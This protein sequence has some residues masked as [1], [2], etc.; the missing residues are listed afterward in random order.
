MYDTVKM[1]IESSV[2]PEV[3]FIAENAQNFNVIREATAEE[4][5][6][7]NFHAG[8]IPV[9]H[10]GDKYVVEFSHNVERLMEDKNISLEAAMDEVARVNGILVEECIL[11]FDESAIEKIDL[12]GL[13]YKKFEVA[14]L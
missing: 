1:L 10:Y 2:M 9:T 14:K 3:D 6:N 8:K 4:R 13:N 11:I 7:V 12:S 5:I